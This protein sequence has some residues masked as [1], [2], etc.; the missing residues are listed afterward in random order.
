MSENGP[1]SFY[2][3]YI[4]KYRRKTA[5]LTLAEH[6]AYRLL[7]D[8]YW[9]A[10]GPL[11]ADEGRLRRIIGADPEEWAAVR[12]AVLAFFTLT[13]D[14]WRHE[15]IEE[16][17]QEAMSRYEA[18]VNGAAAARK[19][20]AAAAGDRP[21]TK[22]DIKPEIRPASMVDASVDVSPDI[23]PD[24]KH[25]ITNTFL[26][27]R[28]KQ[29]AILRGEEFWKS[30][31]HPP[32]PGGKRLVV[33]KINRLP[34]AE[35]DL[36]IRSLAR[37]R[38]AIDEQRKRIPDYQPPM[39]STYVNQRRWEGFD[40]KGAELPLGDVPA[41]PDPLC[42]SFWGILRE[43]LGDPVIRA[44]FLSRDGP[45]LHRS[46]D[47]FLIV[48]SGT[49]AEAIN[50]RYATVLNDILGKKNWRI[51]AALPQKPDQKSEIVSRESA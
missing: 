13:P 44:W 11:P 50:N 38:S 20:K 21:E 16:Q 9:D 36:A 14:G 27:E 40:E 19:K 7:M 49:K 33:E 22:V 30:Y 51:V 2:P 39:A 32:N 3:H 34:E 23:S 47:G 42:V 35:Q 46:G 12:E 24:N 48:A 29:S 6:G 43:T 18:K 4:E 5:H 28:K 25:T 15:T 37:L 17:L 8:A 31:P 41:H 45:V 1:K 10:R 26:K